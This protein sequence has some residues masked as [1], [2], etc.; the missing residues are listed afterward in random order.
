MVPMLR[1]RAHAIRSVVGL[2]VAAVLMLL[3]AVPAGAE[4]NLP[5]TQRS[6]VYSSRT[7]DAVPHSWSTLTR[8]RFGLAT[9]N[10]VTGIPSRRQVS[11]DV[12]VFNDPA[13]CRGNGIPGLSPCGAADMTPGGPAGFVRLGGPTVTATPSGVL[14]MPAW[15]SSPQITNP[16]GAELIFSF[17][18][19]GCGT[20]LAC[21]DD[22][23]VHNPGS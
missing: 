19:E 21:A 22:L 4:G 3:A 8:T 20:G 2:L 18:I 6:D 23:T 14:N 9:V 15:I 1:T 13:A 16:L 11:L 10:H 5:R 12:L 17:N 7:L